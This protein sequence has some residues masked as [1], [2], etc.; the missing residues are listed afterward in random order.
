MTRTSDPIIVLPM[1]LC[2]CTLRIPEREGANR[3]VVLEYVFFFFS[4]PGLLLN[5][6]YQV[7]YF[8]FSLLYGGGSSSLVD[9]SASSGDTKF[10]GP[11]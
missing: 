4:L 9:Y 11:F 6:L 2:A 3:K 1:R 8:L 5:A 7:F 10:T